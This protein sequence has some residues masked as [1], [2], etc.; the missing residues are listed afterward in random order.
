MKHNVLITGGAGRLGRYVADELRTVSEVTLFDRFAPDETPFPWETD[1][2]FVKGDL[3]SLGD[4]MRAITLAE[5]DV[6]VHLGAIPNPTDQQPGKKTI[7]TRPED[8]TMQSNVMGTYY[9]MDAARRL[10]VKKV[11][12]ASSYF[13]LG[14]GNRISGTPFEVEYL[15]LDENHPCRTEDTYSLSKVLGEE[16]IHAYCRAYGIKGVALRLMGI[17]YPF[18][19]H[20]TNITPQAPEN[21]GGSFVSST[22][23]YVDCRD[24]AYVCRLALEKDLDSEFEPFFVVTDNQYAGKPK[25]VIAAAYPKLKDMAAN[26]PDDEG[27]ISCRKLK[28]M[29]GYESQ[30]T[31]KKQK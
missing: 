28:D 19:M 10:N 3:I 25:D 24:I 5:A 21:G 26:I 9:L 29:L 1:L 15:P 27:V 11:I 31:W 6:I 16:I 30:Y 22:H 14:V 8:L 18:R 7:Q 12:F 4:C 17:S 13:T 20:P 2:K 23:Q